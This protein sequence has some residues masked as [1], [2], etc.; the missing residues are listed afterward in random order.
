LTRAGKTSLKGALMAEVRS[1]SGRAD[2]RSTASAAEVAS[3]ALVR[4]RPQD[5]AGFPVKRAP[6]SVDPLKWKTVA[7]K[8][9]AIDFS[10]SAWLPDDWAQGVKTTE[11]IARSRPGAGGTYT[12][13]L[14]P[15]GRTFYHGWAVEDY[16]GRKLGP[17]DGFGGQLRLATKMQEQI[18]ASWDTDANFFKLLNANERKHLPKAGDLHYCIISA[19]RASSVDGMKSIAAVQAAFKAAKIEPVWYV[20]EASLQDYRGLG[21]N[22]VVGGKL[23][24]ARN[25]ALNDAFRMGKACVQ[26]SDDISAWEYRHGPRATSRDDDAQNAAY[27]A[28]R[29]Y[30]VTPVAAARFILAKMRGVADGV[31]PRL[32]G[33]YMLGS[34]SRTMFDDPHS[35]KGFIIGD[36]FVADKSP[37]RFDESMTLKEDYDFT[38]SHL[39]KYGSIMRLNRM[40][41]SAKHYSNSGGAVTVRN[42]KEEQRNISILHAKWPGAFTDNAKRKNEVL[43][44]WGCVRH[45]LAVEQATKV[46]KVT[47]ALKATSKR[48]L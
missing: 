21:L 41:V 10:R 46:K 36:F 17:K 47:K 16:L 28:A 32:G 11:P 40:T 1:K 43:L 7:G 34:C 24:A 14:S 2:I 25:R 13:F 5:R 26:V 29:R 18:S 15:E 37:V 23:T 39:D 9:V 8:E 44:K 33:V 22:A 45:K 30:L 12:V 4:V 38:C 42:T 3:K 20:D 27:D 6:G 19:R 31:P 35:R 48:R